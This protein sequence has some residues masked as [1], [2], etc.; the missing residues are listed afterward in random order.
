[1]VFKFFECCWSS[2]FQRIYLW[3]ALSEGKIIFS[4]HYEK[5][6]VTKRWRR[7]RNKFK[8]ALL[9]LSNLDPSY[10]EIFNQCLAFLSLCSLYVLSFFVCFFIFFWCLVLV[11]HR[12]FPRFINWFII[13]W[14][15]LEITIILLLLIACIN[16]LTFIHSFLSILSA[17][18]PPK[19]MIISSINQINWIIKL[20][21]YISQGGLYLASLV[22]RIHWYRILAAWSQFSVHL[23]CK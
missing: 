4:L 9:A 6:P 15:E 7:K 22:L 10:F 8:I 12:S 19:F 11:F 16:H 2:I 5:W 17:L 21:N 23:F 20:N 13:A 3:L 18:T 14:I 1:M